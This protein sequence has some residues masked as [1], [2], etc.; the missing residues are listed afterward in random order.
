M[1]PFLKKWVIRPLIIVAVGSTLLAGVVFVVLSTQQERFVNQALAEINKQLKG[2]LTIEGSRLSL[3]KN[4]PSI[5]IG[6]RNGALYS[7]KSRSGPPVLTFERLYVGFS[8]SELLREQYDVRILFLQ[9]G[10][11]DLVI[12]EHGSVDLSAL[13]SS[14]PDD[15]TAITTQPDTSSFSIQLKKIVLKDVAVSVLDQAS[16]T[17]YKSHIGKIVSSLKIDSNRVNVSVNSDM[18]ID[19]LTGADTLFYNKPFELAALVDYKLKTKRLEVST[20]HFKVQE[21]GF[22]LSGAADFSDTTDLSFRIKGDQQDFEMFQAFLPQNVKDNLKPFKYDGNIFFDASVQGKLANGEVPG[23]KV[24]F[25]CEDAWF[26]NTGANKRLD[27][28]G[29]KGYFTNGDEHSL[30]T[31]ELHIINVNA[32]PEKGVFKGHFVVRDF[33][34]P[35]ALVQINSELELK[36]LGEFLGIQ[37]LKQMTGTIKLDMDFK[38]VHDITLPEESL[39]KL[40]EGIQSRLAVEDLSFRIP[41]YPH[42]V[43]DVNIHAQ[44]EDG[45]VTV[46]SGSFRIGESDIKISGFI[47]DM[48]GFLRER[49][50]PIRIA[51]SASSDQVLFADLLSYDT[52]L[53]K[54]W[55]DELHAFNID[56]SFET[57]VEELLNP[58]PLPRGT[59]EMKNLRGTFKNYGHTF[60]DLNA[61]VIVN[62]T[63]LRLTDFTGMID[64]SDI[65]FKGRVINY[66]LWFDEIKKGKTQIAFDFRSDRF[67]LRDVFGRE[68]RRLLPRGYRREELDDVWLR[69]KIDLRYDTTFRFMKA[70]V[71]N[72]TGHLKGH[73]LKLHS[74]SGGV[75]YGAKVLS[76]DTLRGMIG[77]TDFDINLKYYFK[78][79]DRYDKEIANSLEFK[80]NL[81]DIDEMSQYDLTPKTGRVVRDST[82]RIVR[83]EKDTSS[84]AD[85]FNVFMIP[86]SDFHAQINIGK[87]KYNRLWLRDLNA[88]LTMRKDQSLTIDTLMLKIARGSVA[89]RGKFDGKNPEKIWFASRIN[90][91][92]VDLEKMMLKLDHFGQDVVVNKHI[93]GRIS[94]QLRSFVRVHPNLV[95]I[96]ENSKAEMTVT[97]YDGSL[98]DFA[99]MQAMAGFFKD[100]NL[101]LIRFDTLSNKF[102]FADGV[103]EIPTMDINSSLGYIQISGRQSLDMN[104][105]YYL[106]VPMKMVTKAGFNSLFKGKPDEVDLNQ[107]DEIEYLDKDRK[108][109]FM[110]LKVTGTPDNYEIGLGK[111]K[112]AR[113]S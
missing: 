25:G 109:A 71:A 67:A 98:V 62:D 45:R 86:F 10:H 82:G 17:R 28:V 31:S 36:F 35:R 46:E 100:K 65:N 58:Q 64:S 50:K 24:S 90:F 94:G 76:F 70:K 103:L 5:S 4:F 107:V 92:Q 73:N 97:I 83:I 106:R 34:N 44:M 13:D 63:M 111:D 56:L 49:E 59:F 110:N 48:R 9:G 60:K 68:V 12:D 30:K 66:Q 3:F 102:A 7:D 33:T 14:I 19:I 22:T 113:K 101:R 51:L 79:V 20:C 87:V 85:A 53:A 15:T 54:R 104:M 72:V 21:A 69:A 1:R 78:G 16:A 96:V 55:S 27:Q 99:P 11:L 18:N 37:D 74:I 95:P 75:K 77:S 112:K 108:I 105:E 32:R 29:F 39:N 23:I 93:K 88:Q 8:L 47:S 41:G 57:T 2:E 6:L 61:T 26:V 84:H 89:M 43:R 38:E 42:T 52:A 80:S 81:L 40:K 91:D